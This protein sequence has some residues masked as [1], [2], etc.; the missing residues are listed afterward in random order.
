MIVAHITDVHRSGLVKRRLR[1]LTKGAD[2]LVVSGD[3]TSFGEEAFLD[4]FLSEMDGLGLPSLVVPG[5]NEGPELSVPESVSN[6]DGRRVE[7]GGLSF[8]GLGGSLL[9][10][11]GTP[12][13]L[14]EEELEAKLRALGRVDVLV[15]HM[16]PL[17][18][19]LDRGA[20]GQHLGSASVRRY[21]IEEGPRLLL[22]GHVHEAR[23]VDLLGR[24]VCCNPGSASSGGYAYVYMDDDVRVE[25][26]SLL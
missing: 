3:I 2:L 13:E 1:E 9:T 20:N 17:G 7:I 26:R 11:F 24:C 8:G 18:T 12:N 6:I 23:A 19:N 22:C 14:T 25:L 16:P 4:E 10:P 15:S 5:N 21:L